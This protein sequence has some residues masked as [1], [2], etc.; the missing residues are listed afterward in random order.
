[1][2]FPRNAR[3]GGIWF[4]AAALLSNINLGAG[5][6]EMK[7][8]SFY[9]VMPAT[10]EIVVDGSLSE[11]AWKNARSH[12]MYYEYWKPNPDLGRL[13]TEFKMLYSAKGVYLAVINHE[14]DMAKLKANFTTRDASELWTDDCDEI[15]IDAFGEGGRLHQVHRQFDW[16]RGRYETTRRRRLPQ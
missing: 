4:A 9:N 13:K 5:G 3:M 6:V 14:R 11:T 8:L 7:L 15:Y 1:M 2:G 10:E 12:S 16:H